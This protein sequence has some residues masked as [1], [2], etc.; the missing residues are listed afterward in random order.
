MEEVCFSMAAL[1][2]ISYGMGGGGGGGGSVVARRKNEG[3]NCGTVP[4]GYKKG[5]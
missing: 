2:K 4:G 5:C 1:G 3:G